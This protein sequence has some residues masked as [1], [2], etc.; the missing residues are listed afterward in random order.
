MTDFVPKLPDPKIE[1]VPG[2]PTPKE[3]TVVLPPLEVTADKRP[4]HYGSLPGFEILTREPDYHTTNFLVRYLRSWLIESEV[5]PAGWLRESPIPYTIIID[6]TDPA[7]PGQ[8]I[9]AP[10][11]RATNYDVFG[12]TL[13]GWGYD[14]LAEKVTPL[15]GWIHAA[16]DDTTVL[17]ANLWAAPH[18]DYAPT[19]LD[20]ID[21]CAP[22]LPRWV[23]AG[24][25]GRY[26]LFEGR[27]DMVY[28]ILRGS[29]TETDVPTGRMIYARDATTSS[30]VFRGIR[31]ISTSDSKR[32]LNDFSHH[33]G[34]AEI[35]F[36]PLQEFFS[37][38]P[39]TPERELLWE[40]EAGLLIRWGLLGTKGRVSS[41]R[42]DQFVKF[43]DR[44]RSEPV[45]E[46]MLTE[47]FGYGY[48][49]LEKELTEYLR[50]TLGKDIQIKMKVLDGFRPVD[51]KPATPDQVGRILGDWLRMQG[52]SLKD[53]EPATAKAFLDSAGKTLRRAWLRSPQ[54]VLGPGSRETAG[55]ADLSAALRASEISAADI[56]NPDFL[57]VC[58]LYEYDIGEYKLARDLLEIAVSSGTTRP[59]A[60][61]LLA[62]LRF[63]EVV[64]KPAGRNGDLSV[65][66]A[67]YVLQVLKPALPPAFSPRPWQLMVD[68]LAHC[69]STPSAANLDM[70]IKGAAQFPRD[71]SLQL[72]TARLCLKSGERERAMEVINQAFPL[73][74]DEKVRNEFQ[75]LRASI[76]K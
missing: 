60:H 49:A 22:S 35:P 32:L 12:W 18:M 8:A 65:A 27:T 37:E 30:A 66:Q 5:I 2:R 38:S 17:G 72:G 54:L 39:P 74:V 19:W 34:T 25:I 21:R 16:D 62:E 45:T 4:W 44:Q 76:R 13:S 75:E 43:V 31:W 68:T 41:E 64:A 23:V 26:G 15:R 71:A 50:K 47:C 58:G 20:R 48:A 57:A 6:D 11:A 61:F 46:T 3:Q 1:V 73:V 52:A 42:R 53:T 67:T 63:R 24:L 51:F 10:L 70:I 55:S 33:P 36:I 7:L 29:I 40:S 14:P 28:A 69:E 56:P 59:R 9:V